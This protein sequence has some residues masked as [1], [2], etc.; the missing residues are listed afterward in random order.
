VDRQ[1]RARSAGTHRV[2][3]PLRGRQTRTSGACG[4]SPYPATEASRTPQAQHVQTEPGP[5][6]ELESGP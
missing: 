4:R 3:H 2:Q 6:P 1:Q 5:K